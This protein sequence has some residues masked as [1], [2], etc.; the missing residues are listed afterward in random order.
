MG[1]PES[2]LCEWFMAAAREK[3]WTCYPE[4]SD[5]DILLVRDDIQVGVQ[6][7]MTPNVKL[8]KQ[9]LPDRLR[10]S[11]SMLAHP[12][13]FR[14]YVTGPNF[15]VAL[16]PLKGKAKSLEN[17]EFVAKTLG[18]WVVEKN[19]LKSK[20]MNERYDFGIGILEDQKHM[21]SHDWKPMKKCWIPDV[22][23]DVEAG[24]K[25][26]VSLTRWKQ[27]AM[28]LIARARVRGYVTSKDAKELGVSMERFVARFSANHEPWMKFVGKQGRFHKY[29]LQGEDPERPDLQMPEAY[30]FFLE[31]ARKESEEI[32]DV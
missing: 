27:S 17:F 19:N 21:D 32:D 12:E 25:S 11:T 28:R 8:L 30:K 31:E 4:T 7:K 10:W 29:A 16:V 9:C 24:V 18:I 13:K 22:V 15:R 6:A 5:W 23:P 1:K 14:G 26:P 3:G 2:D 20:K